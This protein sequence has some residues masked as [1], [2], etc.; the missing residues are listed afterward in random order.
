MGEDKARLRLGGRTL[1]EIAVAKLRPCCDEV[2]VVSG[3]RDLGAVADR[4][5]CDLHPGCGPI[6]GMEAA[7]GD[8]CERKGRW[9]MFGPV[10]MPLVPSGLLGRLMDGWFEH[11]DTRRVCLARAGGR[12]Q[13]LLSLLHAETEPY[14]RRAVSAGNYKV[15]PVLFEAAEDL[16]RASGLTRE[17]TLGI[18]TVDGCGT[19]A[20]LDWMPDREEQRTERLWFQN[21]NT[22]GEFREMEEMLREGG[23]GPSPSSEP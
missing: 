9:A 13:P 18:E 23:A 4:A 3:E 2:V 12:V 17:A 14:L 6:G 16:A 8:L 10:D 21:V 19:L 7:L 22:P 1:V 5:I 20:G 15:A 11:A